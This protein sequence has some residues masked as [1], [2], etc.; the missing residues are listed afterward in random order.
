MRACRERNLLPVCSVVRFLSLPPTP[1]PTLPESASTPPIGIKV[2]ARGV[3]FYL[4]STHG[5]A[6][7]TVTDYRQS[8]PSA[9]RRAP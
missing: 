2:N 5:H 8:L 6:P 9:L 7:W 1:P 3:L 4:Q